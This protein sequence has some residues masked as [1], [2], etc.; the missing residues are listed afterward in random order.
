MFK[1]IICFSVAGA[2]LGHY[3]GRK[4][5]VTRFGLISRNVLCSFS[6]IMNEV[7]FCS[8]ELDFLES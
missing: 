5:R 8:T 4:Q 2:G 6:A 3:G 7:S 1:T